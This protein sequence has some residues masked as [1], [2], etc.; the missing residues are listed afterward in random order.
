M[1]W[2]V[3]GTGDVARKRVFP[4]L[5]RE[6]RSTL[7]GVVSRDAAKGRRYAPRAWEN[8]E[9]ALTDPVIEAVYIATPVFLHC[10]QTLMALRAGKHVLC[11][12]PMALDY[13]EAVEMVR[14]A[15]AGK[16]L[17]GVAYFRRMYP[18]L[19]R[20]REL[21]AQNV[22]GRPLM[23]IAT[24]SEWYPPGSDG[25]DWFFDPRRAG[26]GP[27]Y[28]IGS[29]RID[30]L[31]FLFGDP[32]RVS[33]QFSNTVHHTAVEDSA[34]ALIEYSSG[35][36]AIV[37]ARWNTRAALDDFRIVGVGGEMD[38]SPL[39]GPVLRH[40]GVREELPCDDNRHYPCIENF[41]RAVVDGVPLV[42]NAADSLPTAWVL[43]EGLKDRTGCSPH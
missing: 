1:N 38:L 4:A 14:T 23:A 13:R 20:A 26:S 35:V 28:D 16:H 24:C 2:L 27:F 42:C 34:S 39:S 8:L 36:H 31:N 29:H 19:R 7:Y 41:V 12:K 32:V 9:Q 11:E 15:E 22:I 25:R 30:A 43:S 10:P 18:K 6:P 21:L 17:L 5:E 3:V 40:P 33:A 37:D